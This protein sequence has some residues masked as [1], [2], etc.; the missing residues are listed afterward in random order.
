MFKIV[1]Q[2]IWWEAGFGLCSKSTIF[3]L[4]P[5]AFVWNWQ[6]KMQTVAEAADSESLGR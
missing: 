2:P 6:I 4:K 3:V 5:P 1:L